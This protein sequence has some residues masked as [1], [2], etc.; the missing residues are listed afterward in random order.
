MEMKEIINNI[1]WSI[2]TVLAISPKFA[3][4]C[5]VDIQ[6]PPFKYYILICIIS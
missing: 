3:S 6:K 4:L 2:I 5:A 1:F